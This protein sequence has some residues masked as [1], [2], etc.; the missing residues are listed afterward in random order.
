MKIVVFAYGKLKTP[1]LRA[2]TDYYLRNVKPWSP[3]AEEELKAAPL[4][5]KSEATRRKAQDSEAKPVLEWLDRHPRAALVLLSE[6]GKAKPTQGWA[7]L[8]RTHQERG[9]TEL[10][11]VVGGAFGLSESL[12]ARAHQVLSFGP[13]TFSHEIARLALA[14]QLYRAFSLLNGHPYHH[15]GR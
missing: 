6:E 3:V 1:G 10:A 11:F 9:S 15:E 4:P 14:E 2:A 12:R 7:D 8:I 5:D 13:Q